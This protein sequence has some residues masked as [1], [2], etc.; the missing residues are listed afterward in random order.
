VPKEVLDRR[1][2]ERNRRMV[3]RGVVDEVRRALANGPLSPTARHVHGLR[4]LAELSLGEA[5]EKMDAQMRR[6]AAYQRKWM[7]RI[8]GLVRVNADRPP[9]EVA[10][11]IE[12]LLPAGVTD[13]AAGVPGA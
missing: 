4:E 7:R 13:P 5:L 2:V 3:E 10:A 11:E 9:S 1:I 6:Y 8:P 12:Q